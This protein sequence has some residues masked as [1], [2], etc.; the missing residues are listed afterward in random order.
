MTLPPLAIGIPSF[1]RQ[2]SK[3]RRRK[4][5]G[6]TRRAEL[7]QPQVRWTLDT[8]HPL[9]T[10]RFIICTVYVGMPLGNGDVGPW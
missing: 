2:S 5:V 8:V 7:N 4:S 1:T 10:H 6:L 9:L 3:L